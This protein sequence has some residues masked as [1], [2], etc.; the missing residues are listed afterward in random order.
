MCGFP[1]IESIESLSEFVAE[2]LTN[3]HTRKCAI[4]KNLY[5]FS[6]HAPF[7]LLGQAA[8]LFGIGLSV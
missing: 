5:V 7:V 3:F 4:A 8:E 6:A 1:R 2:K